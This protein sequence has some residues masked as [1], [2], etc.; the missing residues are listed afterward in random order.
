M[1]NKV[2]I[3]G[4]LGRDPELHSFEGTNSSICTLSV[5]TNESYKDKNGD[6][7]EKTEWH[8]VVC[9]NRL[10]EN[11]AN[12]LKKGSLVFVEGSLQTRKWQDRQGET[13]YSTEVKAN[14]I[15]FLEKKRGDKEDGGHNYGIP[16]NPS[17][18]DTRGYRENRGGNNSPASIFK[19]TET[20]YD[21][22]PF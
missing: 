11:C 15:Q 8:K 6:F 9:F 21:R 14:K 16:E 2:F 19:E 17:S 7:I 1:V 5:G 18:R 13:K 20:S 10:A 22:V 4:R 3:L 12:W